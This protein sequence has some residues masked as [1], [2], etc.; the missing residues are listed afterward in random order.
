[1][2]GEIRNFLRNVMT[3][4]T[5]HPETVTLS[6]WGKSR[7]FVR[8]DMFDD[9]FIFEDGIWDRLE[10]RDSVVLISKAALC[11]SPDAATARVFGNVMTVSSGNH[12]VTSLPLVSGRFWGLSTVAPER[13]SDVLAAKM[14]CAKR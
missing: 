8:Y 12:A 1:M 7:T 3:G 2:A 11:P 5:R 10:N 13:Q 6:A 9:T 4:A 14:V